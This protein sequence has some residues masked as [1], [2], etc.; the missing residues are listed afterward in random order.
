[1]EHRIF[2]AVGL[3]DTVMMDTYHHMSIQTL[4]LYNTKY[5]PKCELWTLGCK[6]RL[7]C[8]QCTSMVVGVNE[9]DYA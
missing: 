5:A 4:R 3:G 9:G 6:R 2:R 7:H 1:M 8:N